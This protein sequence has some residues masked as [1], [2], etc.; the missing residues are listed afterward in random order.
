V[1]RPNEAWAE[2][3][4]DRFRVS[5]VYRGRMAMWADFGFVLLRWSTRA[6]FNTKRSLPRMIPA[7]GTSRA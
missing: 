6:V 2:A 1:D 7:A 5:F 3:R 4:A